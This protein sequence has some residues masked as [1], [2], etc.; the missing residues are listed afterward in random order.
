MSSNSFQNADNLTGIV[1]VLQ[2][3]AVGDGTT[4]NIDAFVAA[5]AAAG[6][7]LIRVPV[8]PSGGNYAITSGS[9]IIPFGTKLFF[10]GGS[11]LFSS[12]SGSIT[13]LSNSVILLGGGIGESRGDTITKGV[14]VEI[15]QPLT[16]TG[17]ASTY[18][19]NRIYIGNDRIDA[20][21][22][23]VP[24]SKV[25]GLLVEHHFGG[26]GTKGGRHAIEAFLSQDNASDL[27]NIDEN[28]V[29]LVG[30]CTTSTGD[31]G[32]SGTLKGSYY[33]MN[34][35]CA[36]S[37]T[38]Q[39]TNHVNGCEFNS[40]IFGSASS[41]YRAGSSFV[42]MG[43]SQGTEFDAAVSISTLNSG[44][45]VKWR[46]GVLFGIQNGW[47][48]CTRSLLR[49]ESDCDT[50]FS[51]KD[52]IPYY[53]IKSDTDT[54]FNFSRNELKIGEPS[55]HLVLGSTSQVNTPYI[56]F[57]SSGAGTNRDSRL[58]ATGGSSTA[59]SGTL[60]VNAA[61]VAFSGTVRALNDGGQDLGSASIRWGTVYAVTGTINTSDAREKQ[62]IRPLSEKELAVAKKIK[63]LV[64][65]FKFNDAIK[66]KGE[67]ARI[68]VGVIAQDVFDAF[69][70]EGLDAFEY[71]I[72]CYDEWNSADEVVDKDGS[73]ITPA[74]Q[75]GNR[76]GVRYEELLAFIVSAL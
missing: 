48:P 67:K 30:K 3:G 65:A 5:I 29:G 10:E 58:I 1:S 64:R 26:T 18:Q 51:T 41:K 19:I 17:A 23:S 54:K 37:G 31:G 74:I 38:A 57:H 22:D 68:H 12:G 20:E 42:S 70:S 62:Q 66:E 6:K 35:Y 76:Y 46:D 36:I 34:A 47:Q 52:T 56:D 7:S 15:N 44:S 2:F 73:I 72:L 27:S 4:N 39:Y 33:G 59:E 50:F 25:D 8:D 32:T 24:G 71:G 55:S 45:D 28:Y 11:R 21:T 40:G 63:G 14:A 53:L 61:S 43:N 49:N 13:N 16:N 75:S 9:L 60:V 69:Q